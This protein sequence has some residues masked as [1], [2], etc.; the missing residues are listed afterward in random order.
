MSRNIWRLEALVGILTIERALIR[1]V[2]NQQYAHRAAV[3][4]RRDCPESL[5]ACRIP[6][7]QLDPLPIQLDRPDLEVDANG[8]DE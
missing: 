6:Y 3:V 1:D 5:L 4:C 7:L 8:C 2:V